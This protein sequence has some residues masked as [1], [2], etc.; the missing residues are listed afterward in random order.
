VPKQLTI[1]FVQGEFEKEG[2]TLLT[3]KYINAKQRLEYVCPKKHNWF[4][5]WG[6]WSRGR[7]CQKCFY[8]SN[9]GSNHYNWKPTLTCEDRLDRRYI[10]GYKKWCAAV[11]KKG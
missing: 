10:L 1:E 6:S 11:K 8:E 5:S 4:I 3:K 7:R 9:K 2:Y